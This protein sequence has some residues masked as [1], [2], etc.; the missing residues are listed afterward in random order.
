MTKWAAAA[1]VI[2][3]AVAL[4][5][6]PIL[7]LVA[8]LPALIAGFTALSV[9]SLPITGTI[10]LMAVAVGVLIAAFLVFRKDMDKVKVVMDNVGKVIRN[11]FRG[12]AN[13]V[14]TIW[15]FI[16]STIENS[17]NRIIKLINNVIRTINRIPGIN[18]GEFKEVNL[19]AFKAKLLD[20]E[21][22]AT[23]VPARVAREGGTIVN[24]ENVVGMD[25]EDVSRALSDEL[26]NKRSI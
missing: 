11:V 8:I 3:T 24:I 20:F 22:L 25:P 7:I 14:L 2:A 13:V 15:N 5:V 10:L 23:S 16:V 1:F 18:I 12:I 17:I 26:N 6:G 9:V 19:G 4:I 21:E